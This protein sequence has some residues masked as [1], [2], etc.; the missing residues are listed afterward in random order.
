M[1][2]EIDIRIHGSKDFTSSSPKIIRKLLMPYPT[3]IDRSKAPN[4]AVQTGLLV[5][6]VEGRNCDWTGTGS[7]PRDMQGQGVHGDPSPQN[8]RSTACL[9]SH[10]TSRRNKFVARHT[11][12]DTGL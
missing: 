10:G 11:P 7:V 12:N 9:L 2:D 1:P 5:V 8:G 4:A 6:E 3:K